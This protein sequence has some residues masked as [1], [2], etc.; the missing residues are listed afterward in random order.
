MR[1][2]IKKTLHFFLKLGLKLFYLKPRKYS[3]DDITVIVHPD[4][5]PPQL[6][7]STKILLDFLSLIKLNNKTVLELGC[8]SG[9]I[10]LF[11]S[12][13]GATVIATDINQTALEY[14]KKNS[15][16]NSLKVELIHSDLFNNIENRIFDYIIIN[17]PYYPKIP[18][19]VKEQA[20]FCGEDFEYFKKLFKQL[21]N[22]INTSFNIYMILSEDCKIDYIKVIATKSNLVFDTVLE[23]KVFGEKNYIFQI[24][25]KTLEP[26]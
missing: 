26:S 17:P 7:I 1:N 2:L 8:G 4:V 11:A 5:F 12:K 18:K 9:I 10:S 24:K 22:H 20:W 21:T 16:R 14:L 25:S 3:Y 6:T 15:H 19:N 23:K 13:K